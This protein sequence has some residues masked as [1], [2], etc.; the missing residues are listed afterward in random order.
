M[1]LKGNYLQTGGKM[2]VKGD[3]KNC[4]NEFTG[5]YLESDNVT[6][7]LQNGVFNAEMGGTKSRA[8][9]LRKTGKACFVDGRCKMEFAGP[10][11]RFVSGGTVLLE[12]GEFNFTTNITA[13]MTD[14]NFYPHNLCAIKAD[15]SITI[16]GGDFEAVLPLEGSEIFKTDAVTG[17]FI[18]IS[19][20]RFDLVSGNDCIAANDY[21]SKYLRLNGATNG[22]AF[23]VTPRLP[24]FPDGNVFNL[25]VSVP[26]RAASA[27]KPKSDVKDPDLTISSVSISPD[28]MTTA[29]TATLVYTLTNQGEAAAEA[30]TT[31]L[32]INGKTYSRTEEGLSVGDS[33]TVNVSLPAETYFPS[34][35]DYEICLVAD[36]ANVIDES[37]EDNNRSSSVSV[38]LLKSGAQPDPTPPSFDG[39]VV[40]V[41]GAAV[42]V[43]S[44]GTVSMHNSDTTVTLG[45]LL[46]SDWTLLDAGDFDGDGH[47]GLLWLEN[48][49]G[50]VYMQNDPTSL[51]EINGKNSLLGIDV[52]LSDGKTLVGWKMTNGARSKD[53]RLGNLGELGFSG[54]GDFNSD[55]TDD[56]L[57]YDAKGDLFVWLV[58]NGAVVE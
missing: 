41:N 16:T 30:S 27:P 28:T 18:D 15:S 14:P 8:I 39:T 29:D 6:F 46:T 42:Q 58:R 11:G 38:T 25:L 49:T 57:L 17:T 34:V 53:F 43:A 5:V 21:S 52:L 50:E 9:D 51:D 36:S 24:S 32:L 40:P 12:G 37:N 13:K 31:S 35:G 33:R 3:K 47:E 20:G 56:V 19:G 23:A 44:D 54:A 22:V 55:G 48:V 4:T 26:G 7:T 2:K 45:K 10:E 1:W